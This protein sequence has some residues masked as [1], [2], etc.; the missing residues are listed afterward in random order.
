[1]VLVFWQL[2]PPSGILFFGSCLLL[3][4]GWLG[5]C[6]HH[7]GLKQRLWVWQA[8]TT[9]TR[10]SLPS[11]LAGMPW[12]YFRGSTLVLWVWEVGSA[13]SS[14]SSQ[15]PVWRL[16]LLSPE[17]W[18]NPYRSPYLFLLVISLYLRWLAWTCRYS[19]AIYLYLSIYIYIYLYINIYMYI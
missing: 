6:Y 9:V 2:E 17:F 18:S 13:S 16:S 15:N 14:S 3:K 7:Q 4:S 1:M 10:C 11:L 19:I 5:F 12:R 8:L